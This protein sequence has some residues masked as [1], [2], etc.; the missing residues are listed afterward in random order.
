MPCTV[1]LPDSSFKPSSVWA[2]ALGWP[3]KLIMRQ[4]LRM[5]ATWRDKIAVGTKFKLICRIC[6]P[7]PGI[8]LSPMANVASGV[9][10]RMAGPVP[11]VVKIK[12]QLSSS[13]SCF[14]VNSIS[15][16]SSGIRRVTACQGVV[17]ALSSQS[18]KCGKPRS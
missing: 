7:K 9:T 16:F 15:D 1:C 18:S 13:T 14:R 8:S 10:S 6:S 5:T 12:L 17:S 3:G 4:C 11:P 2:M